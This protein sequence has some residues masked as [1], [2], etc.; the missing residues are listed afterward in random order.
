MDRDKLKIEI[1]WSGNNVGFK[2][3]Y[4]DVNIEWNQLT[5]DEQIT[6]LNGFASGYNLFSRFLK[7]E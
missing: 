2:M 4:D 7:E 3:T 1:T 6:L 5:R